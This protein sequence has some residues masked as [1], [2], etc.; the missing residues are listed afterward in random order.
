MLLC[1]L[2]VVGVSVEG[3]Q[4]GVAIRRRFRWTYLSSLTV[5]KPVCRHAGKSFG[6]TVLLQ[7]KDPAL[8]VSP[9]GRRALCAPSWIARPCSQCYMF[10][11]GD[12]Q[13]VRRAAA[14]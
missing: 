4:I 2:L 7:K 9:G 12:G 14:R 10:G 5:L 3:R 8:K 13:R 1:V 6:V 11:I